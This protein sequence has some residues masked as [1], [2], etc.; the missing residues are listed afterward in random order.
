MAKVRTNTIRARTAAAP[1]HWVGFRTG[2]RASSPSGPGAASSGDF[3]TKFMTATRTGDGDQREQGQS[4]VRPGATRG[5]SNGLGSGGL[6]ARPG[7]FFGRFA[8]GA[9]WPRAEPSVGAS[10]PGGSATAFILI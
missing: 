7:A 9:L 3:G 2:P 5:L 8:F 6:R 1:A 4:A 10:R